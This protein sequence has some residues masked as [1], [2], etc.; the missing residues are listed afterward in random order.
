MYRESPNALKSRLGVSGCQ[1]LHYLK[2]VHFGFREFGLTVET[3]ETGLDCE[4]RAD[5]F[6]Q[7]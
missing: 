3:P 7:E 6:S 5:L 4:V 1:G 2:L